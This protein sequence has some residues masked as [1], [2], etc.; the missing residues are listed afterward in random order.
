MKARSTA[1]GALGYKSRA[2]IVCLVLLLYGA[3]SVQAFSFTPMV[4]H[5]DADRRPARVTYTLQN[6][7]PRAIAVQ[8]SA[9]VRE[10]DEM[11]NEVM[12]PTDELMVYPSQIVLAAGR[13]QEISVDW[14]GGSVDRERAFR[15]VAEQ[16][17]VNLG[18]SQDSRAQLRV[19]LEYV[20]SLYV[21]PAQARARTEVSG[22]AF[23]DAEQMLVFRLEN[24][25]TRHI[26][27]RDLSVL[28]HPPREGESLQIPGGELN[29]GSNVL[30]AGGSRVVRIPWDSSDINASNAHEYRIEVRH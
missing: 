16:V 9:H 20:T 3:A 8:V 30:P 17:P 24:T 19:N 27:L 26:L 15:V 23:D 1:G 12:Q 5:I 28:I 2:L 14:T 6:D 25:G 21:R 7:T 13:S 11:G 22:I 29:A 18:S 10:I 4:S